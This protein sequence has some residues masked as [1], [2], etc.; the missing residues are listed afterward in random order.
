MEVLP[1]DIFRREIAI[2]ASFINPYTQSRAV[3]LL[4]HGKVDVKSL[5]TD[6]VP[7]EEI[8]SIFQTRKYAGR[9]KIIVTP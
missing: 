1:F 3:E 5:I 6:E 2:K 8:G 7:L 4:G 9:G